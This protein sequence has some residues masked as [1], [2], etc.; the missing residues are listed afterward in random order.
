MLHRCERYTN[1]VRCN[2]VSMYTHFFGDRAN[3]DPCIHRDVYLSDN[4]A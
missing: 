3:E 1:A 4:T 2:A